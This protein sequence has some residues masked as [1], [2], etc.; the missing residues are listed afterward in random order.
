MTIHRGTIENFEGGWG[1]G[2][3]VITISGERV[4]CDNGP[5]VRAIASWCDEFITL[6]HSVDPEAITG[7]E[8]VY[9]L[10][11]IGLLE[12]ICPA[13][14]YDGPL[15]E[16]DQEPQEVDALEVCPE[17]GGEPDE[18]VRAGMKCGKCAY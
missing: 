16:E 2:I 14:D 17:C 13:E 15:A 3:A 11:D 7:R 6:G 5:T 4:P 12:W 10:D 8:V 18:R 1:S 9:G